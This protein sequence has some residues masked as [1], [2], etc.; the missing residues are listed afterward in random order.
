MTNGYIIYQHIPYEPE[1]YYDCK[2]Y[3]SYFKAKEIVDKL[4]E[5]KGKF[6]E[7]WDIWELDVVN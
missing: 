6:E 3:T 4:N 1:N 7:P 2:I 5:Q